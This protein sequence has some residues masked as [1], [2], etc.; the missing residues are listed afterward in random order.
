MSPNCTILHHFG[1]AHA[2]RTVSQTFTC[3]LITCVSAWCIIHCMTFAMDR[4]Q[5]IKNLI[6]LAIHPFIYLSWRM[7]RSNENCIFYVIF[8]RHIGLFK[9]P[10]PSPPP[11]PRKKKKKE[12]SCTQKKLPLTKAVVP[13]AGSC[14][15]GS[16][17]CATLVAVH[18]WWLLGLLPAEI[19]S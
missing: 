19:S 7:F 3:D 9:Q 5:A 8:R 14:L 15:H 12:R 16:C 2:V 6:C 13:G 10:P 11:P 17:G 1:I 18:A 4:T